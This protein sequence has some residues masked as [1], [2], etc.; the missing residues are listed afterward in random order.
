MKDEIVEEIRQYRDAHAQKF[1]YDLDAI[2]EDY[3]ASQFQSG[4]PVVR[5]EPKKLAG[6]ATEQ[7]TKRP[8]SS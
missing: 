7:T 4:H 3:M 8:H 1:H 6:K 2:C 5:L